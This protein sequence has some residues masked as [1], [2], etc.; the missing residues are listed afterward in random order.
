MSSPV[1]TVEGIISVEYLVDILTKPFS[2]YPVLNSAG[3]IV[4]MIPKNFLIV[5]I[6]NHHW[7]D[8]RKLDPEKREKLI[9]MYKQVRRSSEFD[10]QNLRGTSV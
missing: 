8:L 7:V 5:L 2:T 3:N 10:Q 9:K 6:E 4:G 1:L